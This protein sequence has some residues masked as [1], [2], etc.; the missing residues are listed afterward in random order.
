MTIHI[1]TESGQM[2]T[3][4][5]NS[6]L[7]MGCCHIAHDCNIADSNVVANSCALAGHVNIG[8]NIII[9]GLAG[10]HQFVHI[11]DFSMIG[12]GSMVAKDIAP[13]TISQGD[14]AKLRG[15]NLIGLRRNKFSKEDISAIKTAYQALFAESGSMRDKLDNLPEEINNSSQAARLIS[16]AKASLDGDRG[17]TLAD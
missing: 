5:G 2:K 17:L 11:G 14:R 9:G 8:S 1:G 6:N 16:F 13:F 7:F 15:L 12:A 4:I 10:I 3:V